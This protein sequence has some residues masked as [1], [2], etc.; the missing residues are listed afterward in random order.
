MRGEAGK[1]R[2]KFKIYWSNQGRHMGNSSGKVS[3][4]TV[5]LTEEMV[6]RQSASHYTALGSRDPRATFPAFCEQGAT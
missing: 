1:D 4:N 2:L 6:R 3:I 5:K